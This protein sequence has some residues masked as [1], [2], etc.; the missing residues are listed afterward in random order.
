MSWQPLVSPRQWAV[1][2]HA[3]GSTPSALDDLR[4]VLEQLSPRVRSTLVANLMDALGSDPHPTRAVW[5]ALAVTGHELKLCSAVTL[6]RLHALAEDAPL[7]PVKP[8]PPTQ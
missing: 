3:L 4:V 5:S 1:I 7:E 8:L 2:V 6:G